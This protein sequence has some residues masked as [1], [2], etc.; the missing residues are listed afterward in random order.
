[1]FVYGKVRIN[2]INQNSNRTIELYPNLH[3]FLQAT[4][5]S[6]SVQFSTD[7]YGDGHGDSLQC[8][9]WL[10]KRNPT[11]CRPIC[12][13]LVKVEHTCLLKQLNYSCPECAI[14]QGS[15]RAYYLTVRGNSI[16][17]LNKNMI[18]WNMFKI[19]LTYTNAFWCRA[20]T[21]PPPPLPH[22][23]N[24]GT[25]VLGQCSVISYIDFQL[26][27]QSTQVYFTLRL[28]P[29]KAHFA[30]GAITNIFVDRSVLGE[31]C[32]YYYAFA[33]PRMFPWCPI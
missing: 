14:T 19:S 16:Y 27:P 11:L 3:S 26:P 22:T 5:G 17:L 12:R 29:P 32:S 33:F 10:N 21:L 6:E 1:M 31:W 28:F 15:D 4:S 18:V 30:Y 8:H 2:C 9:N 25:K 7:E 20:A 13:S 24:F 23:H